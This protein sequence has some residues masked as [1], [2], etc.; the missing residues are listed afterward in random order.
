MPKRTE[1]DINRLMR[2][3]RAIDR[4]VGRAFADA[5]RRHRAAG[6][7]M[8]FSE[9]GTVVLKDPFDVPIPGENG[10]AEPDGGS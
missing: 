5:V 9:N 2:E 10:E 6:V 7:P 3:H 1:V 4:A 8:V